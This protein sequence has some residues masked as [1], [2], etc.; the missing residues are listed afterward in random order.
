MRL[1][2][3][4]LAMA[5]TLPAVAMAETD[6][7]SMDRQAVTATETIELQPQQHNTFDGYQLVSD[8]VALDKSVP[9][10]AAVVGELGSHQLVQAK[11][12]TTAG[13]RAQSVVRSVMTGQL[14]V[15]TGR[16][17]V[18]TNDPATLASVAQQLG[19]KSVQS[20]NQGQLSM[21]QAPATAD[22]LELK[23]TLSKVQ[24]VR[25]TRLDVVE[26]RYKA[27]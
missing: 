23:R 8:V 9:T 16:I 10:D 14:G 13:V 15:V 12:A 5:M 3:I 7:V 21:F 6:L 18:I 24:G 22:L 1:S 17:S 27:Q 26:V 2:M 4:M 25:A 20:L 19:L 11:Q